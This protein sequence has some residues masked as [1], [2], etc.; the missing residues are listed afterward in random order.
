MFGL[1][2]N[3]LPT[4]SSYA[5]A[6][7]I[8]E[9]APEMKLSIGGWR[10]LKRKNDSSKLVRLDQSGA[11]VFRYYRA[12]LVTWV[13]PTEVVVYFHDSNSSRVF[14]DAF[15]PY[16]LHVGSHRGETHVNGYMPKNSTIQFKLIDNKWVPCVTD[17]MV[18]QRITLDRKKAAHA[19]KVIRPFQEWAS[20][21]TAL[22]GGI[23]ARGTPHITEAVNALRPFMEQGA[24]P[25]EHY[26]SLKARLPHDES[27]GPLAY[28]AAEALSKEYLSPGELPRRTPYDNFASII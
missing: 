13:S 9:N 8:F 10:P 3:S 25:Q 11:V 12:D 7:R 14:I 22:T 27:L 20:G 24:I 16:G 21:L 23:T 17:L 19:R 1:R 4:A 26:M 28:L 6:R 15:L 2:S 5:E 18:L